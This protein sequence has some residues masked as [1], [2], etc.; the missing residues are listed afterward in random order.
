VRLA[1]DFSLPAFG[2]EAGWG[3]EL[4]ADS[5]AANWVGVLSLSAEGEIAV[6]GGSDAAAWLR[7]FDR[8]ISAAAPS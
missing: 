4:R 5:V 6:G 8:A 7:P 3:R 1:S 2:G